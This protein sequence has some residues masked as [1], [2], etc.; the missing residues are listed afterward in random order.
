MKGVR[1][2]EDGQGGTLQGDTK[3]LLD[4]NA[5]VRRMWIS[6]EMIFQ[7]QET[8]RAWVL[9]CENDWCV[10]KAAKWLDQSENS[11]R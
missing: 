6:R 11:K 5:K 4:V 3:C 7:E 2:K 9:M 1:I 10:W 8:A